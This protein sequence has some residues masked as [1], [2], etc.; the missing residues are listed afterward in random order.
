M[1][2][3]AEATREGET[4]IAVYGDDSR[5][6]HRRRGE[7]WAI[8][9]DFEQMDASVD[10]QCV[11]EVV[12][13]VISSYEAVHGKNEFLSSYLQLWPE[14]AVGASFIVE[15][16]QRT[17]KPDNSLLT[18]VVGTT[19]FDTAKTIIVLHTLIHAKVDVLDAKKCTAF[20][21]KLGMTVKPGTWEPTLVN[22]E[23][24]PGDMYIE[25]HFLGYTLKMSQGVDRVEP[26]PYL[27]ED[28]LVAI[29]GNPRD[30]GLKGTQ[31]SRYMFDAGRGLLLLAYDAPRVWDAI[32]RYIDRLPY[33]V[34]TMRVT[35]NGG[36]GQA[37]ELGN[38]EGLD[39]P[40]SDGYPNPAWA[41]G[42]FHAPDNPPP[43]AAW[44]EPYPSLKEKLDAFR[45]IKVAAGKI[46][47][48][49][50]ETNDWW[51]SANADEALDA[52]EDLGAVPSILGKDLPA[53][54]LRK[55]KP[56]FRRQEKP[57]TKDQKRKAVAAVVELFEDYPHYY[58]KLAL[59]YP[60]AELAL[61]MVNLG[62]YPTSRGTYNRNPPIFKTVLLPDVWPKGAEQV[63][64]R[65]G[66][67]SADMAEVVLPPIQTDLHTGWKTSTETKKGEEVRRLFDAFVRSNMVVEQEV[68]VL[69]DTPHSLVAV[70]LLHQGRELARAV[71]RS[72]KDAK[73][74]MALAFK[75]VLEG[76]R[77]QGSQDSNSRPEILTESIELQEIQHA[78]EKEPE[79]NPSTAPNASPKGSGVE[80]EARE[81]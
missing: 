32:A 10:G 63:L 34:V 4:K 68:E 81:D 21:S 47:A 59:P 58:L 44:V 74:R 77:L 2:E 51:V 64:R 7:L 20:L 25:T 46:K 60:D 78:P 14:L 52:L 33:D 73:R 5:M 65:L 3:W 29:V 43:G 36:K 11:R 67:K 9:C 30:P 22:E 48:K 40:S 24:G 8:D 57:A 70:R 54:A 37:P 79:E 39:W 42:V 1:Q 71:G 12:K 76:G 13:Y 75:S 6:V 17:S 62:W 19:L 72:Q 15:G 49:V 56:V 38:L 55:P 69:S 23:A 53:Y 50:I 41:R 31:H 80:E 66:Y 45:G 61:T 35:I 18:G 28:E 16:S 26:I 27:P